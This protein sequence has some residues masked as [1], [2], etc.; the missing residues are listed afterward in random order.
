MRATPVP[1]SVNW[2]SDNHREPLIPLGLNNSFWPC[3]PPRPFMPLKAFYI[4]NQVENLS[5]I[6]IIIM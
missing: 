1:Q 6:K 5:G 3:V 2:Y 4:F